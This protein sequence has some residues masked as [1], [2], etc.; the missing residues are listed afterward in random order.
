MHCVSVISSGQQHYRKNETALYVTAFCLSSELN[1]RSD[2]DSN[3]PR[4]VT[5]KSDECSYIP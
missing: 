5:N 3:I 4:A 2:N 1:L